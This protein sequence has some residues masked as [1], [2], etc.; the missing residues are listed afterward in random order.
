M[1]SLRS[2]IYLIGFPKPELTGSKLP[3]KVDCLKVLFYNIRIKKINTEESARLVINQCLIFWERARIPTQ[4]SH[5]AAKKLIGLQTEWKNIVKNRSKCSIFHKNFRDEWK[6]GLSDLFD[7]AHQNAMEM[8]NNE[9]DRQFLI[10]QR[11]KGREG[12]MLGVDANLKKKK[13]GN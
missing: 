2:E 1:A 3:S 6:D 10:K 8:I 9:E 12:C 4:E 7:I 13:R 11:L 5:K